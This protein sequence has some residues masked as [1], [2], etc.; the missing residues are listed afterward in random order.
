MAF[1]GTYDSIERDAFPELVVINA[2]FPD[3]CFSVVAC[4]YPDGRLSRK[5][6]TCAEWLA[7][8]VEQRQRLIHNPT[9]SGK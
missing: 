1:D 9:D 8:P 5:L 3:T 2:P 6:M 7:L 4:Q